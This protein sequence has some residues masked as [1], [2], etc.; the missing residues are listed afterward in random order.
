MPAY[1]CPRDGCEYC[2]PNVPDAVAAVILQ[3]HLKSAHPVVPVCIKKAKPPSMALP[4]VTRDIMDDQWA[5]FMNEWESFKSTTELPHD[6]INRYLLSCCEEDLRTSVLRAEP[7]I[8][9]K[10]E[11][12]VLSAIKKLA[13]MSIAVCTL[14]AD[15]I[16]MH[17]DHTEPVRHFAARIKGKAI[18]GKFRKD[19][20]CARAGCEQST[21]VYFT[22]D[23]VKM[24]LLAGLADDDVKKEVLANDKLEKMSLE[25]TISTVE[26]REQALRS[27]TNVRTP[28]KAAGAETPKTA[29]KSDP[30]LK[31]ESKCEKSHL[32]ASF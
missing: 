14:Q 29:A 7:R 6:G 20:K 22:D 31:K 18:N 8:V 16:Q 3:D 32:N 9:S 27:L 25:Q 15:V 24:V 12:E 21:A 23:I 1:D 17:Q 30:R 5:S 28:A 2:T 19:V 26:I 11:E 10:T 13:V 4:K